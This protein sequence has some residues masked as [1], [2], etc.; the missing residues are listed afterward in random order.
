[1]KRWSEA[2]RGCG[3]TAEERRLRFPCD[4]VLPDSSDALYYGVMCP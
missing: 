4:D 2:T 1:M 3:A